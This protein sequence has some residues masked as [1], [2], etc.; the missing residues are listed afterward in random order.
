MTVQFNHNDLRI[1]AQAIWAS[2]GET[3]FFI[4]CTPSPK[5]KQIAEEKEAG[6][7]P[8][9]QIPVECRAGWWGFHSKDTPSALKLIGS[10]QGKRN[11]YVKMARYQRT[12]NRPHHET[13]AQ[14]GC[15]WL[16]ID[17]YKKIEHFNGNKEEAK[18]TA[19]KVLKEHAKL[20][21][22]V[23]IDSGGGVQA[24]WT[25]QAPVTSDE[26]FIIVERINQQ[27]GRVFGGDM[28]VWSRNSGLRLP[29]SLNLN[30]GQPRLV[31]V[32]ETTGSVYSLTE[33]HDWLK[34]E[35]PIYPEIKNLDL[36]DETKEILKAKAATEALTQPEH[37]SKLTDDEWEK[38][39]E[40]LAVKGGDNPY[41]GRNHALTRLAGK[42]FTMGASVEDVIKFVVSKGCNL[43]QQEIKRVVESVARTRERTEDVK[44]PRTQAEKPIV[45]AS[46]DEET[47]TDEVVLPETPQQVTSEEQSSKLVRLDD[48]VPGI[49]PRPGFD[50][51]SAACQLYQLMNKPPKKKK[52]KKDDEEE[53]VKVPKKLT[54]VDV[55]SLT[56]KAFDEWSKY[57]GIRLMNF[58]DEWYV[59][60]PARGAWYTQPKLF[61]E[62]IISVF[63]LDMAPNKHQKKDIINEIYTHIHRATLK[64]DDPW[65]QPTFR[66]VILCKNGVAIDIDKNE[67]I[68]TSPDLMIKAEDVF[69]AEWNP[70]AQ[71]PVWDK[72]ITGI[73][74][75]HPKDEQERV[76]ILIEDCMS[77]IIIRRNRPRSIS[78]G[79]ILLGPKS[80]GKSKILE[81][82]RAVLNENMVTSAGLAALDGQ[83]A[84][85]PLYGKAAWLTD[86]LPHDGKPVHDDWLKRLITNEPVTIN[87]KFKDHWHGRL[88]LVMMFATN[89]M[90]DMNDQS[91]ALMDR[92]LVIRCQNQ[93]KEGERD[94]YLTEKLNNEKAGILQ[95]LVR[96]ANRLRQRGHFDVPTQIKTDMVD[97]SENQ[98][99]FGHFV[100]HAFEVGPSQ[101][102]MLNTDIRIAF[103]GYLRMKYG[104]HEAKITRGI[105]SRLQAEISN[106]FPNLKTEMMHG[107]EDFRR[108]GILPTGL[109]TTWY[110]A[111]YKAENNGSK[112]NQEILKHL[113]KIDQ[114][115]LRVVGK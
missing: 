34:N 19:I 92:M 5:N 56:L 48:L 17:T 113:S 100:K 22:S 80:T 65:M 62:R 51:T 114:P 77:Q 104:E 29:G 61:I 74:G 27:L 57:F 28:G 107:R 87:R 93:F 23:I 73:V 8:P 10:E 64:L 68:P 115:E 35:I 55:M 41:G 4:G 6:G 97:I 24:V 33:L 42:M 108:Y 16:D 106:R 11:L 76:R 53:E 112:T 31:S 103:F 54:F 58:R 1:L 66:N 79:L 110:D 81:A 111:G 45:E 44:I 98:N 26:D 2:P 72:T 13:I 50:P 14:I 7:C 63:C 90:P 91:Q 82:V 43:S 40:S 83:F 95:M 30:H 46:G 69:E 32:L 12:A 36:D 88:N 47:D 85:L 105:L 15:V 9:A 59:Y 39:V 37:K 67:Q 52:A 38:L 25:L 3:K 78:K 99:D 109:F 70:A 102:Y 84:G 94:E 86:E 60:D 20:P 96:A 21:P 75:A 89:D 18:A 101:R 71:C 49:Y